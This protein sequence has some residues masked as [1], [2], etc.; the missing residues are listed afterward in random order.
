[1]ATRLKEEDNKSNRM[2]GGNGFSSTNSSQQLMN[3]DTDSVTASGSVISSIEG[4]D[5]GIDVTKR[6][7]SQNSHQYNGISSITY[8]E[9]F[10]VG[11]L[12]FVNLIN[13]MDRFT[14]AGKCGFDIW[15]FMMDYLSRSLA[16]SN[17]NKRNPNC[18][19]VQLNGCY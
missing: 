8:S 12:C 5:G 13:Y 9:W 4:D 16:N 11:V 6:P 14:I 19:Y 10:A 18:I 2:S 3:A 7:S 17:E 1:M 15:Q